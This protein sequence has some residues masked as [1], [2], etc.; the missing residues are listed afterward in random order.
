MVCFNVQGWGIVGS[1]NGQGWG[2][3]GTLMGRVGVPGVRWF[4]GIHSAQV[5]VSGGAR[6]VVGVV[7]GRAGV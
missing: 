2:V 1:S 4:T 6:G 5:T 3:M 7:M